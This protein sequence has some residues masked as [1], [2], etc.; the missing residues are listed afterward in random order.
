MKRNSKRF[1]A[2]FLTAAMS[3][4]PAAY[5]YASDQE[6]A[7][8]RKQEQETGTTENTEQKAAEDTVPQEDKS[9]DSEQ[10]KNKET[11]K[12][13]SSDSTEDGQSDEKKKN[14]TADQAG[15]IEE[16]NRADQKDESEEENRVDQKDESEEEN[17]VN[18]KDESEEENRAD[19]KDESEEE[20]SAN[21]KEG[22]D[23]ETSSEEDSADAPMLQS[24][25]VDDTTYEDGDYNIDITSSFRMFKIA[26]V[27]ANVSGD[28]ITVTLD[29]ANKTY[30][31][32]YLGSA[33]DVDKSSFIQGTENGEG[34][35]YIFNLPVEKMGQTIT[36]VPGKSSD[37]SWYTTKECLL[38]VPK[39]M[40]KEETEEEPTPT[41]TVEP[42]QA[43]TPVP[44]EVPAK[45]PDASVEEA[46]MK[47][48]KE[49]GS[50]FKMFV[51]TESS[52]KLYGD[53]IEVTISTEKANYGKLYMGSFTDEDKSSAID[54]VLNE[55]GGYTYTFRVPAEKGGQKIP[56]SICSTSS[57]NW[58][59]K[60]ELTITI[61]ELKK[62]EAEPTPVP[63]EVPAKEPDA[64]VEEAGMKLE[65]ED[66]SE[67]KM[68][69]ITESS[70]KLYGDQIEVT[71]STEKQNY[72]KLY[73]GSYTDENKENVI[74]GVP[75][76]KG[77]Y[78]YTFTVPAEKSGQKV[79]VAICALASGNWYTKGELTLT[80][81]ILSKTPEE[82][83]TV[84]PVPTET[85]SPV[86]TEIPSPAPTG[87]PTPVPTQK[88]DKLEDGKYTVDVESNSS[89][90]RVINCE[91]TCKK[92]K[93]TAV[94]TLSGVGYDYLFAGNAAQAAAAGKS[95]WVKFKENTEGQYTFQIPVTALDEGISIAAHSVKSGTWYDRTLTFKSEGMV[96]VD[97]ENPSKP[98]APTA[99][100][101]PSPTPVPDNKPENES[102][103]EAD[104]SGSTSAV[105]NSTSLPDGVYTPDRFSWSGGSGRTS[106]SCSKVTI[107][108]GKAYA[109]ISFSS[110]SFIYVKAGGNKY[111]GAG[112]FTIPVQL[113]QNNTI[114]GMTTKMSVPHEIT[115]SIFVYLAGADKKGT[116]GTDTSNPS[117]SDSMIST[118]NLKLD[119]KAPEIIGLNT[120]SEETLEYAKYF[121]IFHYENDITLLEI[122]MVSDTD[123]TAETLED[124]GENSEKASEA[125]ETEKVSA[126]TGASEE[127]AVATDTTEK[128]Y[129]GNVVKYL[130]VPNDQEVPAG[131]DKDTIIVKQP[132]EKVYSGSEA[133]KAVLEQLE[134]QNLI[135]VE[136]DYTEI[137]FRD[138]I[139]NKCDLVILPAEI[140]KDEDGEKILEETAQRLS[141]LD[142]PMIVDRSG[143]EEDDLAKEEWLK[144]YGVLFDCSDLAA[145]L[146]SKAE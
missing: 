127:A 83:P 135:A 88:P 16:E 114:I 128:L 42:T 8:E 23:K 44:T 91:L 43:P 112:T 117:S 12:E 99:T 116:D 19:Q 51:I 53:E 130:I 106:I 10:E 33:A 145:E 139:Q 107:S 49:D 15:K 50:E 142:I 22:S 143:D 52:A 84:T 129:G 136:G 35:R 67:F 27:T 86:P 110:N 137:E 122:D 96:K 61:P 20:N 94:V 62:P 66:G 126:E 97:T 60:G 146:I 134:L 36:F 21:Q 29:S 77:G 105:D 98:V 3:I 56:I 28:K 76:E 82:I 48:E 120:V 64:S 118:G 37:G 47:L 113:N 125:A 92:G 74:T 89:M 93:M 90:F 104:L 26:K 80:I 100:P 45:E 133:G 13:T 132:L 54:G 34:Y 65:K 1:L 41:P 32:I 2:L 7:T 141:L 75:N 69:V 103:H 102:T 57:G 108:G 68:F 39:V 6:A 25:V 119:E 59:T 87:I 101:I 72:D 78:T 40:T 46:G 85:P 81:P 9:K 18:Q 144:A 58:Y 38:T 95:S 138:I 109:T 140:L 11:G 14:D 121:K 4:T 24:I 79:N 131:L 5:S 115:Y 71:I 70:A 30:D 123:R 17:R 73:L 124:A 111:T 63:T 31:R 55:K